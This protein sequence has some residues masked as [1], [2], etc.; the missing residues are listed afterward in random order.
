MTIST[1][2]KSL[3]THVIV[4]AERYAK[5]E[6]RISDLDSRMTKME[7]HLVDIK[8]SLAGVDSGQLKTIISIGTTIVG[9]LL[10]GLITLI[11]K[12]AG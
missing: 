1:E 9:V 4:C 10:T 8:T 3:H 6:T 2:E 5:L 11:V 7:C 12:L